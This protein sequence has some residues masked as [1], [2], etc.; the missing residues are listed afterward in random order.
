[1]CFGRGCWFQQGATERVSDR[2]K[3]EEE[4]EERGRN[5]EQCRKA[6]LQTLTLLAS[7]K[8]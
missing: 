2:V 7:I 4:E 5:T 8:L 6:W 3:A 1:M